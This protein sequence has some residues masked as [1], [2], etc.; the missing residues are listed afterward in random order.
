MFFRAALTAAAIATAAAMGSAS[1]ADAVPTLIGPTDRVVTARLPLL[2][3]PSCDYRSKRTGECVEGVDGNPVDATAECGDGLYS[4]SVTRSGTCSHHEGVGEWCP[5]GSSSNPALAGANTR[6][7]N[8]DQYFLS[9]VSRIPGMTVIDPA[10]LTS[11]GRQI[12]V[13]LQN[14]D[15]T[16]EDAIAKTVRST[17]N[18]TLGGATALIGAAISA[19]CPQFGG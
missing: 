8:A 15:E 13:Y 6:E 9:L 14:G 5:C 17:P 11:S 19:Y 7:A 18:G 1:V 3:S 10:S 4:H 2:T 16:R 12:C